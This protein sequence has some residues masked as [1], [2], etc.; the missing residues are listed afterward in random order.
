VK[1]QRVLVIYKKSAYQIY[2]RER[3]HA[4]MR[5]LI[6]AHDASV[7]RM[8][9]ADR[10]HQ[11]AVQA[12]RRCL[13]AL[14]VDA[15]FRYRADEIVDRTVDLVVT[16]G[17]DG[18]LLWAAHRVGAGCPML[19]INSAPDDSVGF[20]CSASRSSLGDALADAL[21]GRLQSTELTRMEVRVDRESI[22]KRVLNDMLFTHASPAATARYALVHRR[23]RAQ[24]KSSGLWVATAAGSTAAMLSAG[25]RALPIRSKKL[26]FRV[27]ELYAFDGKPKLASGLIAPREKLVIE[28]HLRQGR[29]FLDGPRRMHAVAIG[30]RIE[31]MR[32]PEPLTL[33]GRF[34]R[35][36]G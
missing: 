18:T 11:A 26:Q 35:L 32:S 19:A 30:A 10:E 21:K 36:Q 3:R 20:F 5:S 34:R 6:R 17:G 28:S 29:L 8:I 13:R 33:L 4:R 25:G 16:V 12:A 7:A 15:E 27:R 31:V 1:R 23:V 14:G 22:S 24:H 9:E 2:V